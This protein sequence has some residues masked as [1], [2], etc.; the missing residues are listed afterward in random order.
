MIRSF[1]FTLTPTLRGTPTN[2]VRAASPTETSVGIIDHDLNPT[3]IKRYQQ[4]A[5]HTLYN[6]AESISQSFGL[7]K[8]VRT[9]TASEKANEK[10]NSYKTQAWL[11]EINITG[12]LFRMREAV[13]NGIHFE[14]DLFDRKMRNTF[15]DSAEGIFISVF[16]DYL[17][18]DGYSKLAMSYG[19]AMLG[20]IIARADA[21]STEARELLDQLISKGVNRAKE[22]GINYSKYYRYLIS[23]VLLEQMVE[24]GFDKNVSD[25]MQ[26]IR[27]NEF[28]IQ[29]AVEVALG[30]FNSYVES[31][32]ETCENTFEGTGV[33]ST[34]E[35]LIEQLDG[36]TEYGLAPLTDAEQHELRRLRELFPN[37]PSNMHGYHMAKDT[38]LP[39]PYMEVLRARIS[40]EKHGWFCK[41]P[42]FVLACVER[43]PEESALSI[44]RHEALHSLVGSNRMSTFFQDLGIEHKPSIHTL[45]EDAQR[46]FYEG[47]TELLTLHASDVLDDRQGKE[48]MPTVRELIEDKNLNV[49]DVLRAVK[50]R[51][52]GLYRNAVVVTI[53]LARKMGWQRFWTVFTSTREQKA[54]YRLSS[55]DAKSVGTCSAKSH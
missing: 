26:A 16:S 12:P 10:Y 53:G 15:Y 2:L 1:T 38:R 24:L 50:S 7:F 14:R 34:F 11:P 27:D 39:Y 33:A 51:P 19:L 13:E 29:L 30:P 40:E 42:L 54:A 4:S 21:E 35:G 37:I 32:I 18:R 22:L 17:R 5:D 31:R 55:L 25:Q 46:M 8:P 3:W 36:F 28:L 23:Q 52:E 20:A 48:G 43:D 49:E 47:I 6:P 41:F 9:K 45:M 44:L